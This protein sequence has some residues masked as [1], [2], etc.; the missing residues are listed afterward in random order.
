[1]PELPDIVVYLEALERRVVGSTVRGFR[2]SSPSVLRTFDPPYDTVV[3]RVVTG[4]R[5]IGKRIVWDLSD[6][7]VV[8]IHLM[9]A[10]RLKWSDRPGTPVPRKVGLCAWDF[11]EG[12]L[13]LTEQGTRKRAGV[14]VFSDAEAAAGEDRGGVEPLEVS[15]TEFGRALTA[16]NRTLKRALTDPRI[17]SGIGNAFSDEILWEA[18]LSPVKRTGQ[19]SSDEVSRLHVATRESLERWTELLRDQVGDGWPD[20]VT[21]FRPEMA[22]HG[23]FGEPCPRCGSK[24]QRIVYA[25]NETNY[26]ATCQTGGKLLADRSLSRLLKDDWPATLEDLEERRGP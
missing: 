6:G 3:G 2:V 13:V 4:V 1:M 11:D 19:L 14:W 25:S 20:K 24:V 5:R 15:E 22:V 9:V 26:C 10:G 12:S 23:K 18:R 17:L 16:E 21:A 8:V 7:P